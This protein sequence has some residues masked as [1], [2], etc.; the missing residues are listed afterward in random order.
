VT[1][2]GYDI[3]V[4]DGQLDTHFA[5]YVEQKGGEKIQAKRVDAD[6]V[7][8]LIPKDEKTELQLSEEEVTKTSGIFDKAIARADMKVEVEALD[9]DALPVSVT[10]DEFMR[11]MKDMAKT[12][13]GMGFYGTI[14]DQYKVTVNGNHPLVKRILES[15]EEEGS[16]LAKQAFDLALLSRGLLTGADLTA[17]VKR[18]V[19]LI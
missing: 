4:L 7:D 15:G 13:G 1:A 17:F 18:S 10:I 5:A 14:P 9:A 12:G 2:K 6:V 11:R 16:Q 19:E 8:K 3:L